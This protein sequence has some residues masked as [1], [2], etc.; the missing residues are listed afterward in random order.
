MSTM[1]EWSEIEVKNSCAG[2]HRA[3]L[4]YFLG[5]IFS[6]FIGILIFC[7]VVTKRTN[8]VFVDIHSKPVTESSH[9]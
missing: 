7:Y 1:T 4:V 9:H 5:F 6:F 3:P 8:P 2:K